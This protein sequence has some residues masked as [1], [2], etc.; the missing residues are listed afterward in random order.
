MTI[1]FIYDN[2]EN[3]QNPIPNGIERKHLKEIYVKNFQNFRKYSPLRSASFLNLPNIN[4]TKIKYDSKGIYPIA[5]DSISNSIDEY[6]VRNL[7]TYG[8]SNLAKRLINNENLKLIVFLKEPISKKSIYSLYY[9]LKEFFN[10]FII[11]SDFIPQDD[12]SDHLRHNLAWEHFTEINEFKFSKP[13]T[14]A[15]D[16][17]NTEKH[18]KLIFGVPGYTNNL[19]DFKAAAAFSL[20]ELGLD[21]NCAISFI[22]DVE[23][24]ENYTRESSIKINYIVESL[25]SKYSDKMYGNLSYDDLF[26]KPLMNLVVGPYMEVNNVDGIDYPCI[27][28]K[29]FKPI[30]HKLPFLCISQKDTLKEFKK[31]GYK[32]FHPYID[33]SYDSIDNNDDRLFEVI[34][35]VNHICNLSDHDLSSLIEKIKPVLDYNYNNFKYRVKS[36]IDYLST[37]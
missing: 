7:V 6:Q 33:E 37:H 18:E 24:W 11:Y 5:F 29:I 27:A 13:F 31:R 17:I 9:T 28:D 22:K 8:I 34:K 14:Q 16:K 4:N 1:N 25:K 19:F 2:L 23:I 26:I 3:V 36:E 12:M 15:N 35:Q 30:K 20:M 32:T 10:E 21:K